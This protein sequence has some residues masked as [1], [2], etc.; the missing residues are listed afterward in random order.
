LRCPGGQRRNCPFFACLRWDI[1]TAEKN[2]E[3]KR[4]H[5][6]GNYEATPIVTLGA[7]KYVAIVKVGDASAEFEFDVAA[8][9]SKLVEVRTWRRGRHAPA[10]RPGRRRR[11]RPPRA[12]K[13]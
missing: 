4:A 12:W 5:I 13:D 9:D 10:V 1:Y 8:G 2:L 11:Y 6:N 7:G 3:G